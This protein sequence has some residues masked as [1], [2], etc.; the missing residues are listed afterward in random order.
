MTTWGTVNFDPRA[1]IL[2]IF[3]EVYQTMSHVKY[4][5]C[6][7]YG[8][9][10]AFLKFFSF[11]CHG[12]H[13]AA[14]KLNALKNFERTLCQKCLCQVLS[15]LAKWFRSHFKDRLTDNSHHSLT[16]AHHEHY[17][18]MW[19]KKKQE[20]HDGPISLTLIKGS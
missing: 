8:L 13:N 19:A 5:S 20:G 9:G 18:H 17:V 3:K 15:N 10:E 12:N 11:C 4:L 14:W 2:T 1:L 6:S 16:K 7:T